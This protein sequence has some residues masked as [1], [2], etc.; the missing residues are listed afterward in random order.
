M[1][2]VGLLSNDYRQF[3]RKRWLFGGR[4]TLFNGK[5]QTIQVVDNIY[6]TT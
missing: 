5:N 6:F 2:Q 3:V 1:S 4:C